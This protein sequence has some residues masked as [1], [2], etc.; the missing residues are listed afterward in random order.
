MFKGEFFNSSTVEG[1]LEAPGMKWHRH[2]PDVIPMWVA[3]PDFPVAMEIKKA[4]LN[5]VHDED[6]FYNSDR[7]VREAMAEKIGK[8]NGLEAEADDVMITQGVIPNMWLAAKYACNPGD[9]VLTTNPIYDPFITAIE[10]T[11]TKQVSLDIEMEEG[12]RLDSESLKELVTPRTKLIYVCNP[13]NPCGRVLTR[14]ELKAIADIAVDNEILVMSDEL[15]EDVVFD[16][17][18]HVT[19]ASLN[20]D[21]ERLT[22]TSWGFS[23]LFGV[24]GLQIGYLCA[25]DKEMMEKIRKMTRGVFRGAST[26]ARAA[27][28]VMLDHRLDWWRRDIMEHLQK[29]RTLCENRLDEMPGVTYPKL[30]GTYLMFPK[31]DHGKTSDELCEYMLEEAKVSLASGTRFGSSGEGH[32]RMTIATSEE[33]VSEAMNRVENALKKLS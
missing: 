15:W 13:H 17:R 22:M 6:L 11:E 10:T 30:E 2:P 1:M 4:L 26:L 27:A 3:D 24:A 8:R 19:L 18:E 14:E 23:K 16:G 20:P 31:F 33:I 12:Y 25:T 32:L 7:K 21:V 28:P 5:A 9:E 29:V